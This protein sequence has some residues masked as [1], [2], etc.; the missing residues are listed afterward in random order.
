MGSPIFDQLTAEHDPDVQRQAQEAEQIANE[1]ERAQLRRLND[2]NLAR[3][4]QAAEAREAY[5]VQQEKNAANADELGLPYM[6]PE[7][8]RQLERMAN[9][10]FEGEH[11]SLTTAREHARKEL[12]AYNKSHHLAIAGEGNRAARRARQEATAELSDSFDQRLGAEL[13]NRF[14]RHAQLSDGARAMA[15][16]GIR[17]ELEAADVESVKR[18]GVEAAQARK[19]LIAERGGAPAIAEIRREEA[20]AAA[21]AA[22]LKL[23]EEA[24]L[25]AEREAKA[26][27]DWKDRM[28]VGQSKRKE[29]GPEGV[30]M[31]EQ[32]EELVR[33]DSVPAKDWI[34]LS[35]KQ[36]KWAME[37][38]ER[39]ASAAAAAE[40]ARAAEVEADNENRL[41]G[42][43]ELRSKLVA[44]ESGAEESTPEPSGRSEAELD[45]EAETPET[46]AKMVEKIGE[47]SEDEFDKL[48]A[49]V[50]DMSN[51]EYDNLSPEVRRAINAR[52]WGF[53][54]EA[55]PVASPDTGEATATPEPDY[56][57]Y[58]SLFGPDSEPSSPSA[59]AEAS[60][61]SPEEPDSKFARLYDAFDTN[62]DPVAASALF[63]S[64]SPDERAAYN[65]YARDRF[66]EAQANAAAR[67]GEINT[68]MAQGRRFRRPEGDNRG[69]GHPD[70]SRRVGET[71]LIPE[72]EVGARETQLVAPQPPVE[73]EDPRHPLVH[74][75]SDGWKLGRK[76]MM[77]GLRRIPFVKRFAR[78]R[79]DR[80]DR[81]ARE[82]AENNRDH[83]A[84]DAEDSDNDGDLAG[85]R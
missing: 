50:D 23:A 43:R 56:G 14:A 82:L 6:R 83:A 76:E 73:P 38:A 54:S 75:A 41:K 1:E 53:T 61:S 2:E 34:G 57:V 35:A 48:R 12:E 24:R 36:K 27:Q 8:H 47:M 70:T 63:N 65:A 16:E 33:P 11:A 78:A 25:E 9:G 30:K 72:V 19:A 55:T 69:E 77:V 7:D 84:R 67:R 32:T 5:Q 13:E 68:T 51:E 42:L 10:G 64:L 37:Q 39:E 31:P 28:G 26:K 21:E 46:A 58:G 4:A 40:A 15:A 17:K 74:A 66:E 80:A 29:V 85:I 52:R 44:E 3:E 60:A 59:T 22:Q 79:A 81:I 49:F 18:R 20:A 62:S 71:A 45:A